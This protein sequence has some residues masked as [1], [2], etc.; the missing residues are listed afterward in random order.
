MDFNYSAEQ[1]AYRMQV[2]TWLEANQP[3]PL[4]PEERERANED[5]LW[6]RNKRWHKKLYE[7]G[8]AGLTWPKEYGGSRRHFRRAGDL[9]AGAVAPQPADGNQRPRHNH[10]RR[11]R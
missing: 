3:P 1:E 9:P 2:R 4:T 6:E 8:W 7:G 5:L 10:D 11:P